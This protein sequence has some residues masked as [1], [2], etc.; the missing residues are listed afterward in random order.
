M[1]VKDEKLVQ[2]APSLICNREA[3]FES[4]PDVDCPHW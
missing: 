2:V 4:V 1:Y 3:L